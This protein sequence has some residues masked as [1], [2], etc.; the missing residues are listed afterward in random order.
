MSEQAVFTRRFSSCI[1]GYHIYKSIWT[2]FV[3]EALERRRDPLNV[4]DR[5]FVKVNKNGGQVVGHVPRKISTIM[6]II[7][8]KR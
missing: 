4:V 6:F 8:S 1:R 5:Y 7:N 3:G 2:P